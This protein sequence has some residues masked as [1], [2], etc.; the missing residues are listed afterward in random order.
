MQGGRKYRAFIS[1]SKAEDT[2]CIYK[3]TKTFCKYLSSCLDRVTHVTLFYS[4]QE[5]ASLSKEEA[6]NFLI[7]LT[8]SSNTSITTTF[9]NKKVYVRHLDNVATV[10]QNIDEAY[11]PFIPVVK[12][13]PKNIVGFSIHYNK[14][15][16]TFHT[17]QQVCDE[18]VDE[19]TL[20]SSQ[21]AKL[22]SDIAST[23]ERIHKR[24]YSVNGISH[25]TIGYFKAVNTFKIL[26]WQFMTPVE[27]KQHDGYVLY[28]HPLKSYMNG[29]TSLLAKRNVSLGSLL[30]K[31]K[32]VKKLPSYESI[33]AYSKASLSYILETYKRKELQKFVTQFD[34]YSLALLAVFIGEKN[35]I[36]VPQETVSK[37][38]SM[39]TPSMK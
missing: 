3:D 12:S 7:T 26:D 30:A 8:K 17:F 2:L 1:Q 21:Y 14:S 33:S 10:E 37:W 19:M 38:L 20:S 6:H 23:V 32:W 18:Y 29:T 22:L 36:K 39:F 25:H 31:N 27:K 16:P 9:G 4:S 24:G 11:H 15:A 35:N 34:Y 28:S 13:K 5:T